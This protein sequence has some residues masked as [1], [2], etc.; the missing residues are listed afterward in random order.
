MPTNSAGER[1]L[2][3]TVP[4]VRDVVHVLVR[5]RLT[6][7][8]PIPD[9]KTVNLGRLEAALAAPQQAGF[10]SE[11]YPRL[12]DKAAILAYSITK[13]HAW[14]NGN[15]RMALTATLLFLYLNDHWWQATDEEMRAHMAWIGASEAGCFDTA[16]DYLR[17]YF[18]RKKIIE[19]APEQRYQWPRRPDD[20]TG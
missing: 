16:M 7:D 20:A 11:F 14:E 12:E 13:N 17:C 5:K 6:A 1:R 9:Y 3:L 2:Y 8:E 15:K 10:G 18:G 19:L 4:D